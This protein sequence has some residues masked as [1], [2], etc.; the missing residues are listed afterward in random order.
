MNELP[1]H[2]HEPR[3]RPHEE[4]EDPH[5]HDEDLEIQYDEARPAGKPPT[6]PK[7]PRKLPPMP[8]RHYED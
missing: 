8:R 5:F 1:P 4:L 2:P 6:K 7:P 3:P